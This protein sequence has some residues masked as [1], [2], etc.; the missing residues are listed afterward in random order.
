MQIKN[1]YN[2]DK[3][4]TKKG[5]L[6]SRSY[7]NAIFN[8]HK[9]HFSWKIKN[10]EKKEDADFVVTCQVVCM[11]IAYLLSFCN[12]FNTNLL[13][14]NCCI[15]RMSCLERDC[16]QRDVQTIFFWSFGSFNAC[17]HRICPLLKCVSMHNKLPLSCIDFKKKSLIA[18]CCS[19]VLFLQLLKK[20][21]LLDLL[22]SLSS[23][24]CWMSLY[25]HQLIKPT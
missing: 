10:A 18:H 23:N 20:P 19:F 17:P 3:K 15:M 9:L 14:S 25:R 12:P 7:I 2:S 4:K 24:S 16:C 13:S 5:N 11:F 22:S 1:S 6:L 21:M 8:Y